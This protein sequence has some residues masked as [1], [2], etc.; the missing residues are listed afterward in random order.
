[1]SRKREARR[2]KRHELARQLGV[3]SADVD[4]HRHLQERARVSRPVLRV[5]Q[6]APA[7]GLLG[8][9]FS[10][11]EHLVLALFL[12]DS[13]G[14]RLLDVVALDAGERRLDKLTYHRPAHFVLVA[15]SAREP[16]PLVAAIASATLLLD[17]LPVD[18]VAI[19]S[20]GWEAP[21]R[22]SIGGLATPFVGAAV[23]V[24]GVARV[25]ERVQLPL[26]RSTATVEIEV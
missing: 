14:A 26:L 15:L 3:A 6:H 8:R 17:D 1:M 10:R 7:G 24:R 25:A 12:V 4:E 18:A 16:A 13:Q 22:V 23:S 11:P 2:D 19:A 21:R 20:A 5:V 9:L